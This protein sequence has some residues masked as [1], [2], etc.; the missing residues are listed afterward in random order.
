M[1]MKLPFAEIWP[2]AR[3]IKGEEASWSFTLVA[4]DCRWEDVKPALVGEIENDLYYDAELLPNLFTFR[5]I[6]W[7]PNVY[8]TLN[9]CLTGLKL[10]TNYSAELTLE[11]GDS[12]VETRKVY[13]HLVDYIGKL[14]QHA[15]DELSS[16]AQASDRIPQVLKEFRKQSFP[17]IMLFIHHPMN[18]IDYREDALRRVNFMVKTLLDQYQLRFNDLM[19]PYWEVEKAKPVLEKKPR[20]ELKEPPDNASTE[21]PT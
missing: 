12:D 13:V 21:S 19:L 10:V 5:E 14:A 18:R 20:Q 3:L 7:Q 16:S 4:G 9:A 1:P 8:P 11:H 6:F 15:H 17:V 2:F